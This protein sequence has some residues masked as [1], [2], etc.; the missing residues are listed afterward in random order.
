MAS[1]PPWGAFMGCMCGRPFRRTMGHLGSL[2]VCPEEPGR[3]PSI[4]NLLEHRGEPAK[5]SR[6]SGFGKL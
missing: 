6:R 3:L 5:A 2:L 1:S 4:T